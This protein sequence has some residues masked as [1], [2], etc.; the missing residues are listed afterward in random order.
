[1]VWFDCTSQSGCSS[2][3]LLTDD[4]LE[5]SNFQTSETEAKVEI[6]TGIKNANALD[7]I[8]LPPAVSSV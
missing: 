3:C 8:W 4:E 6:A 2:I 7:F 5:Q 1:M